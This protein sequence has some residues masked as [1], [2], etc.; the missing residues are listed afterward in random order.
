MKK[1]IYQNPRLYYLA[2][3]I[4]GLSVRQFS[5]GLSRYESEVMV[6][7][8]NRSGSTLLYNILGGILTRQASPKVG[9]VYGGADHAH[10]LRER[11]YFFLR[12]THAYT[13]LLKR[14]IESG[15]SLAFFSYRNLMDVV[16]SHKQK[17]WVEDVRS[18]VE[19]GQ[20]DQ[21]VS[22]AILFKGTSN[23]IMVD[24]RRLMDDKVKL[25]TELAERLKV[26]LTQEQIED[27]VASV[28]LKSVKHK[29]SAMQ[30]D[31]R[32]Q[33]MVNKQSG[34]HHNHINDPSENK[35]RTVLSEEEVSLI[36]NSGAYGRFRAAFY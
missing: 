33:N 27:I 25:V 7:G 29:M 1:F 15:A 19:S 11:R 18:F 32:G 8:M 26:A 10:S 13:F 30:F 2:K 31:Q 28:S 16:A 5:I 17:G 3:L 21:I 24:Y 34:L 14:R 22:E 12:K 20:L 36:E 9:F 4:K 23:I 35:Y 6:C